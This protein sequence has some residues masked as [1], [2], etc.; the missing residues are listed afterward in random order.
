MNKSNKRV[1]VTHEWGKL[2]EVV[3]GDYRRMIA[4]RLEEMPPELM[5]I[6]PKSTQESTAKW[7]GKH[8]AEVE[9]EIWARAVK[10]QDDWAKYLSDLGIVVHRQQPCSE[11]E[12]TLHSGITTGS[13]SGF[14][15]DPIV[16]IGNHLIEL[17]NK[18]AYRDK[19]RFGLRKMIKGFIEEERDFHWVSM[20]MAPPRHM[21]KTVGRDYEDTPILD[22][23][24]IFVLGKEILVGNSG[25]ASN[26]SGINWLRNYLKPFGYNVTG[27][28]IEESFVHLDDGLSCIDEGLAIVC[29]EQYTYGMP[30]IIKG[31]DTVNVTKSEAKDLLAGNGMVL[32]PKE[33]LI[34][35][36]LT[37][38]GEQL[39]KRGVKVHYLEFDAVT[40]WCGGFRCAHHPIIR[41]V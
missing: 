2:K 22:G 12:E 28:K 24:D 3:L 33:T 9:P 20:P 6:A 8:F 34:D 19:E 4:P 27:I 21:G 35:A 39:E 41:E 15:R 11:L 25:Q 1:N 23:G 26:V 30:E 18:Y 40:S 17:S 38:I 16:V 13:W 5:V 29:E 10:Q 31:W 36:R 32:G 37:H 7:A 14:P